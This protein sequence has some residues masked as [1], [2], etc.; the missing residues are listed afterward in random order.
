MSHCMTKPTKRR[1]HL[2]WS[3]FTA[4]MKKAWVL[5]LPIVHT[6]KA[7]IGLATHWAHSEDWSDWADA[8]AVMNLHCAHKSFCWFCHALAQIYFGYS[9]TCKIKINFVMF[10]WKYNYMLQIDTNWVAA[11]TSKSSAGDVTTCLKATS[12]SNIFHMSLSQL[13]RPGICHILVAYHRNRSEYTP[14]T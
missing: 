10:I 4:C 6:M 14:C 3:V 12:L 5:K 9:I 13:W 8:Q 7:L 2:V 11:V 1:V